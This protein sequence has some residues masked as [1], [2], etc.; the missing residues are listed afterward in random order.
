[1]N[2]SAI[3]S[4]VELARRQAPIA[5]D[6]PEAQVV[7]R[8]AAERHRRRPVARHDPLDLAQP[9]RRHLGQVR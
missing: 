3:V 1:M 2:R 9:E 5:L 4:T 8:D 7:G 6:D